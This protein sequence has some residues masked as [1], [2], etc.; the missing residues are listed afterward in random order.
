M[1]VTPAGGLAPLA[2]HTAW[3]LMLALFCHLN[4]TRVR[5]EEEPLLGADESV[6]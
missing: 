5:K 3:F 4:T 2:L 6:D 1:D